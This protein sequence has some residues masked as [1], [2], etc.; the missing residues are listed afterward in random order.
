MYQTNMVGTLLTSQAFLPLLRK[1]YKK[2]V[3][4]LHLPVH[5]ADVLVPLQTARRY[6]SC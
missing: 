2:Q 1:G 4:R 3:L 6:I 5:A